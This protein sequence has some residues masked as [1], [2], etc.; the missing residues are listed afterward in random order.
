MIKVRIRIIGVGSLCLSGGTQG[1]HRREKSPWGNVLYRSLTG[2]RG[3]AIER[4]I[5]HSETLR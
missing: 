1:G 2:R 4:T 5:E 3:A